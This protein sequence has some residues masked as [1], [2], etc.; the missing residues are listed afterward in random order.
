MLNGIS[1]VFQSMY[2]RLICVRYLLDLY[3]VRALTHGQRLARAM[4]GTAQ[5]TPGPVE[6]SIR[7]KVS[8][9]A[10]LSVNSLSCKESK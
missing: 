8:Y 9:I 3:F 10:P 5:T 1:L 7:L 4:S 2:L 6:A